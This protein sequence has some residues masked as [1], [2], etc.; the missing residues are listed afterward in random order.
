MVMIIPALEDRMLTVALL[1]KRYGRSQMAIWRW[2][3]DQRLGFPTP[4]MI[5]RTPFWRLSELLAW[6]ASRQQG[7][8]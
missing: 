4:V 5:G 6:E 7:A 1:T 8:A 2:R 3:N